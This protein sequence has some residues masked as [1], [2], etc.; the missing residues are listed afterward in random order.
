MAGTSERSSIASTAARDWS[1]SSGHR[2]AYT[3]SVLDAPACPSSFATIFRL[4]CEARLAYGKQYQDSEIGD[5]I[6]V[7]QVNV[8]MQRRSSAE[9]ATWSR[10]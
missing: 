2:C 10:R 6:D 7:L 4:W 1:S 3:R 9:G 5:V 8:D